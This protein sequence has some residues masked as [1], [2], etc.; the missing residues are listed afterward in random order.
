MPGYEEFDDQDRLHAGGPGR[1]PLPAQRL[2]RAFSGR[3]GSCIARGLDMSGGGNAITC[4]GPIG[5]LAN[6]GGP[7]PL[8]PANPGWGP[9]S[10]GRPLLGG[11]AAR[12]WGA[13]PGGC[14]QDIPGP[15]GGAR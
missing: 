6:G 10:A 9:I 2:F 8:M 3:R 12:A 11:P 5:G 13:A 15:E 7:L 4:C 1:G 14:I